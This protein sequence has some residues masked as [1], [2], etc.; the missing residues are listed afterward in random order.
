M[1]RK[2]ITEDMLEGKN[3][4]DI[5]SIGDY[6]SEG[7]VDNYRNCV[8]PACDA[9]GLMQMGEAIDHFEDTRTHVHRPGYLTFIRNG[10][11]WQ[12]A[13]LC[14]FGEIMSQDRKS[15]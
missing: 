12:Y 1:E 4:R 5:A 14:F 9:H 6:V 2:Y 15:A 11:N 8:P 13:G 3:L 10:E 7:I